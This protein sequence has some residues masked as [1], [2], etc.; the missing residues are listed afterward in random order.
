[1]SFIVDDIVRKQGKIIKVSLVPIIS[2]KNDFL[3]LN[4]GVELVAIPKS[5]PKAGGCTLLEPGQV[6][7]HEKETALNVQVGGGHYKDMKIQP[8]EYIVANNIPFPEGSAIKYLSRWRK[9]GG[10]EDLKKAKH[11]IDLLIQLE[12]EASNG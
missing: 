11:F 10:I 1:M 2:I 7:K 3:N 4:D 12:E 8:I 9:K 6:Y 5:K